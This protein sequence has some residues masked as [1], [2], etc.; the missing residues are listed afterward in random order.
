MQIT[1]EVDGSMQICSVTANRT[2]MSRN[3]KKGQKYK[4]PALRRVT[5]VDCK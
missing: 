1:V 3:M 4:K 5:E 2:C